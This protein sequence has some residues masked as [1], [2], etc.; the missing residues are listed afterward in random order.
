MQ[1]VCV[2]HLHDLPD[3]ILFPKDQSEPG[4]L[5]RKQKGGFKVH[6]VIPKIW[7][8]SRISQQLYIRQLVQSPMVQRSFD[9][10]WIR[11]SV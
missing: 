1:V 3:G 2:D 5:V 10:F 6:G 4:K 8:L 9:S 7:T 11:V